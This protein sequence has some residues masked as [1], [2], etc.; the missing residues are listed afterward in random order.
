[1][2]RM[3]DGPSK[4]ADEFSESWDAY[5]SDARDSGQRWPGD[6]WG[7]EELWKAWFARLFVP[8]GVA[9][10]RRAVE[11]GQGTGK[12][13]R[14][15]LDA[16]PVEVLACDVSK[17]FLDLCAQRLEDP[18][19]AGRLHLEQISSLDPQALR[20]A[21]DRRGW[22]GAVDAV[23]SID[24]LVHVPF[25]HVVSYLLQATELLRPG[26]RFVMS[27]ANGRT[28]AGMRKLLADLPRVVRGAGHPSTGCFHW[29]CPELIGDVARAI[30]Y[31]VEL[32]DTDPAHG[33]DGHLVARLEDAA[34]AA[35]ARALAAG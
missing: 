5:A 17:K 24:S 18:V 10:W 15:V 26:G 35:E 30:G 11:I 34:R 12:Y 3:S 31:A 4:P 16:G 21:G 14:L 23:Y 28:E 33:R 2:D 8:F 27:F 9:D 20:D 1:M 29:I 25:T 19:E 32:C 22:L 7:D 13:T 6:D